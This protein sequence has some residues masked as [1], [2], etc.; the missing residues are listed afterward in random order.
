[1]LNT[2]HACNIHSYMHTHLTTEANKRIIYNIVLY[3]NA[4]T[5]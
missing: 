2:G 1:M 3:F 4:L 5:K